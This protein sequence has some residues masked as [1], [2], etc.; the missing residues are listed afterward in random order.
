MNEQ[1]L[2]DLVATSVKYQHD[3]DVVF[4]KF[5]ELQSYDKQLLKDYVATAVND[6]YNWETVNKKFPEFGFG[7]QAKPA[8]APA[9][10]SVQP[11]KKKVATALPSAASSSGSVSTRP[12]EPTIATRKPQTTS[13]GTYG[14][15]KPQPSTAAFT[16]PVAPEPESIL[17]PVEKDMSVKREVSMIPTQP[18]MP[19]PAAPEPTA[20]ESAYFRDRLSTV[21]TSLI[22]KEE[23]YVVPQMN[24]QFGNLGFKFEE[25]GATG[26]YMDVT[27]PNGKQIQISLDNFS[28]E[29]SQAESIKLQEFIKNNTPAK[30]LFA[31][32][33]NLK[34]EDR[35]FNSQKQIDDAVALADKSANDLIAKQKSIL[36]EKDAFDKESAALQSIPESQRNTP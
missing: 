15:S 13:F 6:N 32:E 22:S 19:K 4:G 2:K 29:K 27:A 14:V 11:D 12:T 33:N 20:E 26:D 8:P 25:A 7:T 16:K 3:W 23:E 18:A 31:L 9:P 34:E 28:D 21:N 24:Y 10:A 36:L 1:I 35:K 17:G 5:P 30:G